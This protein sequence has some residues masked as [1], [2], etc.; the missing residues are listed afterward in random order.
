[1]VQQESLVSMY[2]H[3]SSSGWKEFIVSLSNVY[4]TL[5][6]L[7]MISPY[8]RET[9][10]S[11]FGLMT[12]RRIWKVKQTQIKLGASRVREICTR[13]VFYF[14]D[15]KVETTGL[16]HK[17]PYIAI[18]TDPLECQNPWTSR[19]RQIESDKWSKL[20]TPWC[21]VSAE[22]DTSSFKVENEEADQND[23][24]WLWELGK[25]PYSIHIAA[26]SLMIP[27][28]KHEVSWIWVVMSQ[29]DNASNQTGPKLNLY[30]VLRTEEV[31]V[32]MGLSTQRSTG[33]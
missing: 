26:G 29:I 8:Y 4:Y 12:I 14:G 11:K 9:T 30:T 32:V 18:G 25:K 6:G 21:K 5:K 10:F 20:R 16:T 22:P 28:S 3:H 7:P 2:K 31:Q 24:Y 13:P 23:H 15:E 19:S 17:H 27:S 1:M 33:R